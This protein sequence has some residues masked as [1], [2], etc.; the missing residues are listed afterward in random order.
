VGR[1]DH[2][3]R[4]RPAGRGGLLRA[5]DEIR[6][7]W[8]AVADRYDRL[9]VDDG[10]H[11]AAAMTVAVTDAANAGWDPASTPAATAPSPAPDR[12]ALPTARVDVGLADSGLVDTGIAGDAIDQR[13]V[14][15]AELALR[16]HPPV[17]AISAAPAIPASVTA[18]AAPISPR[19][20]TR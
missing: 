17:G 14:A 3:G 7:R 1:G 6:D 10:L 12:A 4:Q 18:A 16:W 2:L 5:E 19:D 11:P 9:R 8:P 20:R 15:A 13:A